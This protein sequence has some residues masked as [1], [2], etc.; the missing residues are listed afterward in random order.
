MERLTNYE[1]VRFRF[2]LYL[3][4]AATDFAVDF[5]LFDLIFLL[6]ESAR[7]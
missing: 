1:L 6:Q 7:K 4:L 3:S 2:V 5:D